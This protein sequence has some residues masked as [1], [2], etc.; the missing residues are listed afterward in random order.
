MVSAPSPRLRVAQITA[1]SAIG[2]GPEHVWQLLRHLPAE[3]I[4][5]FVAAPRRRPYEERFEAIVGGDRFQPLP[6]R[7]WS[8]VAFARLVRWLRARRIGLIHSHGRGAGLYGRLAALLTGI[9]CVH[10][11]HGIHPPEGGLPRAAYLGIERSLARVSRANVAVSPSEGRLAADLGLEGRRLLVIPNGVA[12]DDQPAPAPL[13]SPFTV[14]HVSR[15]DAAKNS[16]ALLPIAREMRAQELLER[17]RFLTVGEGEGRAALTAALAAEGLLD[18]FRFTGPLD[19]VRSLLRGAGCYL[20]TSRGEGLPL[21]VLEAQAEGVPA[22]ASRVTG[23]VDAIVDGETGFL[24]PLDDARAAAEGIRRLMDDAALRE[25]MGLAAR[26]HVREHHDVR[27]M[28]LAMAELYA[29][30]AGS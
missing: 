9:P 21:A 18:A 28:A 23:N 6:Q 24:F 14:V 1:S 22:V 19:E 25:R 13:R 12:V 10:S 3:R 11:F 15:F 4:E 30:V 20:S 26:R 2:G 27:R 7:R 17:C 29:A 5:S 8:T 16:G